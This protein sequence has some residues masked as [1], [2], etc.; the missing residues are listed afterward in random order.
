MERFKKSITANGAHLVDHNFKN[1]TDSQNT[2][3]ELS[4]EGV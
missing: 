3:S 2:A 4:F 1:T